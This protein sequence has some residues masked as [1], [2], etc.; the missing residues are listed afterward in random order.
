VK[1][2]FD[3][4]MPVAL[5]NALRELG[6]PVT[7]TDTIRS[8]GI[9]ALDEQIVQY[10]ADNGYQVITRDTAMRGDPWFQPAVKRLGAGIFFI[11]TGKSNGKEARMWDIAK[12]VVKAW[13]SVERYAASNA[14]PFIALIKSNGTVSNFR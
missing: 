3:A 13:D 5:A 6:K 4:N 9:G 12:Q 8:L 10:A 11:R 14:V 1:F 7:H 2:L